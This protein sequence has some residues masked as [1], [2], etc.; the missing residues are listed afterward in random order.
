MT[1]ILVVEDNAEMKILIEGALDDYHLFFASTLKE[2]AQ[3]LSK[4][5]YSLILLD[6]G[7]PDGD[8]FKLLT[9]LTSNAENRNL[10]VIILSGK[11]ETAN[12]VMAFSIGAEDFISK[13]FDPIEL[14][15]RVAAKIK[16]SQQMAEKSEI[17]KIA[18]L[19]INIP[20]Q[21]VWI[22]QKSGSQQ[23]VDLTSLEF[24]LLIT[25][26][27]SPERVYSREFLLDA[28]WGKAI[29]IT[30]RTVDT[31]IGHLRKKLSGSKTKIDTVIGSGYRFILG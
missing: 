29:N 28:V 18:D 30:D 25:L 16:K 17:I 23:E 15:A 26:A 19:T 20:K 6:L 13:P 11:S 22:S 8:G 9:E 5:K 14:K 4:K 1:E 12:K 10:P 24:R 2:A 21:K 3:F 31:H 7:L 27:K